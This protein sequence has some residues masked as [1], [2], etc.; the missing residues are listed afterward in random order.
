MKSQMAVILARG[1]FV[2]KESK[3]TPVQPDLN[4]IKYLDIQ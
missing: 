3:D 2:P 4:I 1:L